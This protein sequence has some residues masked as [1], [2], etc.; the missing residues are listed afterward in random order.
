MLYLVIITVSC[1][2]A[3]T[4]FTFY[5]ALW[6]HSMA[7][8]ENDRALPYELI[9]SSFVTTSMIGHYAYQLGN[10]AYGYGSDFMLQSV[11]LVGTTAFILGSVAHTPTIA[12]VV[13]LVIGV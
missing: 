11:L 9:F 12:F 3:I 7:K 5:W 4:I 2:S 8:V 6:L 10:G 13:S 1:E